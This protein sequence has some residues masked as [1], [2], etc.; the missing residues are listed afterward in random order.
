VLFKRRNQ[1]E[2]KERVRV[3]LW[4][5]HSWSRSAKYVGKRILRLSASPHAV[6]AGVAA[7]V[8]ASMTPFIGLHF[9]I[10]FVLAFLI[11]GNLLAAALGTFFGNPLTFPF[12]WASTFRVGSKILGTE[13]LP[14]DQAQ[15]VDQ[16][17]AQSWSTIVPLFK[18]M[19]VGSLPLGLGVAAFFY[20]LVF[21]A[22]RS[23]Q[24]RR[25]ERLRQRR[26]ARTEIDPSDVRIFRAGP[27]GR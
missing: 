20:V 8:L 19:I 10:G 5:R 25:R 11:G 23:Y 13:T 18:P 26:E 16:L 6:A 3:A 14:L 27:Q 7:G 21:I 2:W 4:P 12:I 15:L 24:G 22:V 9:L 17:A 1:P